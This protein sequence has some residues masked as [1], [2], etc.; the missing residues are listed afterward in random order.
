[1]ST[2]E[3]VAT[4]NVFAFLAYNI[5]ETAKE[6]GWWDNPRNDGEMIAL[7]HSELSEMLEGLRHG[8]PQSEHIPGFCAAEEEAADLVIRLLDMARAREWDI[9]RAVIAKMK[10]NETRPRKHGKEF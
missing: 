2:L 8:N 3:E 6:K 10:F 1:M 5:H 7:M 4:R 9:G